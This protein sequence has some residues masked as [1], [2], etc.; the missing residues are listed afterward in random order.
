MFNLKSDGTVSLFNNH[1]QVHYRW[2]GGSGVV[3]PHRTAQLIP[4]C[5]ISYFDTAGGSI[6]FNLMISS[7]D[8]ALY[9]KT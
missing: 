8:T 3:S 9:D 4:H 6:E 1:R 2:V 7:I 5:M